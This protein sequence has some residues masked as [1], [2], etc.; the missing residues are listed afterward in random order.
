MRKQILSFLVVVIIATSYSGLKAQD[1]SPLTPVYERPPIFIGPVFGFNR[2]MHTVELQTFADDLQCPTFQ[3]G[4]QNGFFLG[5]SYEYHIGEA[6]TSTSS[7]IARVLYNTM[8]ASITE[9]GDNVPHIVY[10]TDGNGNVISETTVNTST[11]HNQEIDYQM[12]TGEV[13]YKINPIPGIPLGFTAGP[14]F[15]FTL[16][17]TWT[18]EYRLVEPNNVAFLPEEGVEYKDNNRTA[19]IKDGDI[20]DANGFRVGIK[21]G[22]QYEIL[23]PGNFYIVP[24]AFYNFGLTDL[25]TAQDWRVSA[26][27][28]GVD[29]RFAL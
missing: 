8:P 28:I 25:S 5:L 4:N 3:N 1:I 20:D 15:D 6:Q 21:A 23:M 18:Q 24:A 14:T 12:I 9:V 13:M 7:I 2:S 19:V 10:E 16:T 29:V 22:V 27:Q 11:E 26:F 17:S